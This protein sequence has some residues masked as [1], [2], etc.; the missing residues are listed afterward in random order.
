MIV[1]NN[2]GGLLSGKFNT[3][4]FVFES[5]LQVR[6]LVIKVLT[7]SVLF[8]FITVSVSKAVVI[9][10]PAEDLLPC[11]CQELTASQTIF[12]ECY[13]TNL[14]DSRMSEIMDALLQPNVSATTLLSLGNNSL[15]RV[16]D[17]ITEMLDLVHVSLGNNNINSIPKDT[18]NF[19]KTLQYLG[20]NDN[21]LESIAPGAF[22]GIIEA[23]I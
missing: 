5:F 8:L 4:N 15:T 19:T 20:L 9:C 12:L 10:P 16:P 17:R 6:L 2:N 1:P 22:Q 13:S 23:T 11:E 18:F 3:D 7:V 14:K 21:Q